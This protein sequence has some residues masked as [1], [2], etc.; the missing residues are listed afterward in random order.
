MEDFNNVEFNENPEPVQETVKAPGR[1][2]IIFNKMTKDMK[3]VGTFLII[4][5]ALYCLTII[6]ALVGVP[7]IISGIRLRD[8]ADEFKIFQGTNDSS[9]LRKGF[10]LQSTYFKI[11]KIL[12]IVGIVFTVLY[13]IIMLFVIIFTA[14]QVGNSFQSF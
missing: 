9:A 2:G 11:H 7:L 10:E 6:G 13:T 1:F 12:Y 3:V 4:F 5:G 8:S 14:G